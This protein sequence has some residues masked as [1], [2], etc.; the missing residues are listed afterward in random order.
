VVA[1]ASSNLKQLDSV[2]TRSASSAANTKAV[3][4]SENKA[5]VSQY[6]AGVSL[7]MIILA[8][9]VEAKRETS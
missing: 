7:L 6:E 2:K 9:R 5:P 3:P 8:E 4:N 1:G